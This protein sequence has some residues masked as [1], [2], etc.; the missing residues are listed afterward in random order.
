MR[1]CVQ[2]MFVSMAM[3]KSREI[4]RI[5]WLLLVKGFLSSNRNS[6]N[7]SRSKGSNS[8]NKKSQCK[9]ANSNQKPYLL[10][11]IH[12]GNKCIIFFP[13][14]IW[15]PMHK[16][17]SYRSPNTNDGQIYCVYIQLGQ[18]KT[19][20]GKCFNIQSWKRTWEFYNVV[21]L[22]F[23]QN[24]IKMHNSHWNTATRNE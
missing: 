11:Q 21:A 14:C 2:I 17:R 6:T 8:I 13:I 12:R 23:Q 15:W 10:V 7:S 1:W 18:W 4:T 24:I 9:S 20:M 5:T 19:R 16:S 22:W 3:N